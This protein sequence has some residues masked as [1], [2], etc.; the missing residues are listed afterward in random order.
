MA[1]FNRGKWLANVLTAVL[2][3]ILSFLMFVKL[4]VNL[5]HGGEAI[6]WLSTG[7]IK[8]VDAVIGLF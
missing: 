6:A 5:P 8:A 1:W 2:F 7:I 4:D 3:S